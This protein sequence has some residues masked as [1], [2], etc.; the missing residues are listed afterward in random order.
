MVL[1]ETVPGF[2]SAR[3]LA[4][5][6]LEDNVRCVRRDPAMGPVDNGVQSKCGAHIVVS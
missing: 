2:L 5:A 1:L 4:S 3:Q 6:Q